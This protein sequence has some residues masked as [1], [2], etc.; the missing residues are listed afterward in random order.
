MTPFDF[1]EEMDGLETRMGEATRMAAA[2][3]STLASVRD[4]LGQTTRDLGD[5]RTGFA[6]GLRSAIDGLVIDGDR[7]SDALKGVGR[8]MVDTV[9][10]AAMKPV[11][12]QLGGLLSQGLNGAVSSLMPFASGGAFS[13][14]RVMPFAKGGVVSQ[15]T[16]FPMRGGT[17]LMGEAGPEAIMPLSRGPDG[18]L[19]VRAEGSART[20]QVTINV[21][22]PDV[23]GFRR[24]QSQI[25]A[26]MSRLLGRG[27]RNR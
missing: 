7:L 5:L 25:A 23:A 12:D 2:F 9:Y 3:S 10:K 13:Q 6:S 17:G 27:A 18:R 15:A 21:T 16:S 24:S 8:T 4:S 20:P 1:D 26:E 14:G 19:G 22:T 11:T